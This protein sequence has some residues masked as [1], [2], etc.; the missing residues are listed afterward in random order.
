MSM[1]GRQG[2]FDSSLKVLQEQLVFC[3]TVLQPGN[4]AYVDLHL[5]MGVTLAMLGRKADAK[6]SMLECL[7]CDLVPHYS[8]SVR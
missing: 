3:N 4:Y 5:N 2:R 1:Y 7:R 6:R 8:L